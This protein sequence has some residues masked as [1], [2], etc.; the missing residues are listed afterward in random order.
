MVQFTVMEFVP[1]PEAMFPPVTFQVYPVMPLSVPYVCVLPIQ[2]LAGPVTV[3]VGIGL[4]VTVLA[5][6][7]DAEHPKRLL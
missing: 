3:G 7:E 4:T 5:V 1:D 2:A 6:G